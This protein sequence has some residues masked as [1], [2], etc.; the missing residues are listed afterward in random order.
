MLVSN[1]FVV[2]IY[3]L[4]AATQEEIIHWV[5]NNED[6]YDNNTLSHMMD[7]YN[8][9]TNEL[10]TASRVTIYLPLSLLPFLLCSVWRYRGGRDGHE[11][12]QQFMNFLNPKSHDQTSHAYPG[13]A[14][15]FLP[16]DPGQ[17]M[18]MTRDFRVS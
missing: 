1:S 11:I 13:V 2:P 4:P 5:F 7:I 16:A 12:L 18:D 6:R 17:E 10:Y 3:R 15:F 8:I 9:V 14:V